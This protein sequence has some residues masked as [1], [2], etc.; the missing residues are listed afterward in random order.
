MRRCAV[1]QEPAMNAAEE[2]VQYRIREKPKE[3]K[4]AEISE[5]K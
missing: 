4:L 2:R 1:M 3:P 5:Q